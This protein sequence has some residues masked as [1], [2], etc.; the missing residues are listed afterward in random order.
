MTMMEVAAQY[1]IAGLALAGMYRLAATHVRSNTDATRE[2]AKE[3]KKLRV[4]LGEQPTAR[5]RRLDRE[6]VRNDDD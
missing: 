4:Q 3:F 5:E 2:L 6:R 1:G